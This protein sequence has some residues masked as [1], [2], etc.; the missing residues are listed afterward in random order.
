VAVAGS[1]TNG[2][3]LWD[4]KLHRRII[5]RQM[6]QVTWQ[7]TLANAATNAAIQGVLAADANL[8]RGF[9][10]VQ[11]GGR[12][13]V[14][15]AAP[16]AAL[17]PAEWQGIPRALLQ[18]LAN[19]S[20]FLQ[21]LPWHIHRGARGKRL[22]ILVGHFFGIEFLLAPGRAFNLRVT[23]PRTFWNAD[24]FVALPA[25]HNFPA[26]GFG[27][28]QLG[29]APCAFEINVCGHALPPFFFVLRL[30]CWL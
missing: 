19:Q 30:R 20:K 1:A 17:Q 26:Q 10:T 12:L 18:D 9:V 28:G 4:V 23:A 3:Q 29:A 11:S 24:F 27:A 15:A 14:R 13:Q 2:T 21:R 7:T 16:A 22:Q 6:L 25:L 5:G 8:Q